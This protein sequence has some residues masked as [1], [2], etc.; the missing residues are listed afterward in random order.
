LVLREPGFVRL[1]A[2]V[3]TL[4]LQALSNPIDVR[5]APSS[6][7]VLWGD[8]HGQT[9]ETVGTGTMEEYFRY[10]RDVARLDFCAH[11]G[12]DFQITGET[13]R[14]LA[15]VVRA[16]HAPGQFVTFLGYEWSGNT[17]AG[18]D[19]NVL[20][21]N[22]DGPLH[23]SS[24]WQVADKTDEVT[25]RYPVT[26][27]HATL[28][29]RRDV[30]MIPHVG[31]R[32]CDIALFDNQLE[33]V[34]EICSVWGEF[35]W[36]AE[37]ALKRGYV[38]GVVANS[39]DHTCRPGACRPLNH[40]FGHRGGLTAVLAEGCTRESVWAAYL[41]RRCY[42]T[43]GE[44]LYLD[45]T[46]DGRQMGALYATADPPLLHVRAAGTAALHSIE[47]RR[48]CEVIYR[49]ATHGPLSPQR[50]RLTWEGARSTT[51]YR[52]T[53]WDGSLEVQCGRIITATDIHKHNPLL[54]ITTHEARRVTWRS[55]TAGDVAGIVVDLDVP[56]L[57]PI[58][59]TTPPATFS[60]TLRD[61]AEQP[62]VV[63][64]GGMAQRVVIERAWEAEP[65]WDVDFT[66][67]DAGVPAGRHAYWVRLQQVDGERAWS[68]PVYVDVIGGA[69][70]AR[71]NSL[72]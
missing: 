30:M 11:Q 57:E 16:F 45:V 4:G 50:L 13:W 5:A 56:A 62:L 26:D 71:N 10:G 55:S 44:R 15:D 6:M 59:F 52:T 48:G 23:R 19:R 22:D 17:A 67:I 9:G 42:A 32:P 65:P 21:L 37:E 35:E 25:D 53:R 69:Y 72:R 27:L 70:G 3:P 64:A 51:R 34:V 63:D 2:E 14:R 61:V 36:L 28:R 41:E 43:S 38:V 60:F 29:G 68:S 8:L 20:F 31:G 24:H 1:A 54:G 39:D 40:Q 12:N 49:H 66:Y 58:L 47:V 18:G 46:A 33:H 7:S